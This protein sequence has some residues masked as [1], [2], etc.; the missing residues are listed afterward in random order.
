M[1]SIVD[2]EVI[3]FETLVDVDACR[4]TLT[5][6]AESAVA[7]ALQQLWV[8]AETQRPRK[9]QINEQTTHE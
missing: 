9:P 4:A 7:L 3:A 2:V 1:V 5:T 6:T 8:T